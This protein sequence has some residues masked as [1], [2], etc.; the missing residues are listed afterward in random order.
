MNSHSSPDA[1]VA[2][3][4]PIVTIFV[5]VTLIAM[6]ASVLVAGLVGGF[7]GPFGPLLVM[8]A[9]LSPLVTLP[10]ILLG[11]VLLALLVRLLL[12]SSIELVFDSLTAVQ[13]VIFILGVGV[14]LAASISGELAILIVT[15]IMFV[16]FV[17]SFFVR[18]RLEEFD[19]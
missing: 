5:I 6:I 12:T 4:V 14:T 1:R 17:F 15:G 8:A 9:W 19:S 7:F 3:Q 2:S 10:I 16:P 11:I 13:V 18:R